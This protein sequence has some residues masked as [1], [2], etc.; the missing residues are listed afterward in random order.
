MARLVGP[1][2]EPRPGLPRTRLHYVFSDESR[3]RFAQHGIP[4]KH[5]TSFQGGDGYLF[6]A[7]RRLTTRA[8]AT[9]IM[10]GEVP[11]EAEDPFYE[12]TDLRLDFIGRLRA[13]QEH[14]FEHPGYRAVLSAFGPN[15]L[16]KTG[17]RPVKRQMDAAGAIDRSAVSR[18]RAIPNNAILQQFGY[19]ANVV[20]GLGAAVGSERDRFVEVARKSRRLRPLLEM[21]ARGKQLSSLNAMGANAIVFDP[22]FWAWRASWGREANLDPAFRALANLLL[23][24]DR[25]GEINSLVH[26]LRLDAVE[27]HAMLEEIGIEGGKIPDDTRLELDLLQAIRLALIMRV[28]I[29]AAQMPRFATREISHR[30]LFEMALM[31]DVPAVVAE[32]RQAFPRR[33]ESGEDDGS[34]YAEKATY[35]PHGIDDYGRVETEILAPM[36]E[37]YELIREI[38][39]GISHYFG[40]F[41]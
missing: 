23:S 17:S 25:N 24:D 21:I 20:A 18:M 11:A 7:N 26:H 15:I 14:L 9:V 19:V 6:F 3:R 36:E 30:Q 38:G 10:D 32:M 22:G 29:L 27:L 40:A 35:R 13:Y 5:E 33:M 37:A 16:F 12:D 41:G 4:I 8:L 1:R 34:R 2:G 39:T 31:L 28:F